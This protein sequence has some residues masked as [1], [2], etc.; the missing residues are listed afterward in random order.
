MRHLRWS[1][2]VLG[3]LVLG[4]AVTPGWAK[5]AS[6]VTI[7]GPGLDQAIVVTDPERVQNLAMASL[8]AVDSAA[9]PPAWV[10]EVYVVTRWIEDGNPPIPF[11]QVLY[12]PDPEGGSALVYYVGIYNGDGPYDR[13]WYHATQAGQATMTAILRE[14]GLTGGLAPDAAPPARS[15]PD[16]SVGIVLAACA[17]AAAGFAA[18]WFVRPRIAAPKPNPPE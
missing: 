17:L 7:E 9:F 12:A 4:L 2:C 16:S 11:D 5:G 1:G 18:G 8:E 10:G 6:F 3:V 15:A 14:A 13:N